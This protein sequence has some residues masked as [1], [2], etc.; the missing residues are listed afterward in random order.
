MF[1]PFAF[2]KQTSVSLNPVATTW[3]STAGISNTSVISAVSTF[4]DT[5]QSQAIWSKMVAVYPL[6][7]DS[8]TSST[9]K[10]QFTYN[11]VN[12]STYAATYLNNSSTGGYGGLTNAG[13]DTFITTTPATIGNN[14]VFGFY[15]NSDAASTDVID[16]GVY[17]PSG[18]DQGYAY[19]IAGRNKVGSNA[20]ILMAASDAIFP[21]N[22]TGTGPFTGL[23][24]VGGNSTTGYAYR[25]TSQLGTAASYNNA[26][27][28]NSWKIGLGSFLQ[29]NTTAINPTTKTYQFCFMSTFLDTTEFGNLATAVND[30]QGS[31]DTIFSTT[32]KAY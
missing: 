14:Y 23:F 6:I 30:L 26:K 11:L 28:G 7:S 18:A 19:I 17:D 25:R 31:I 12:P 27:R 29:E 9:A 2:V 8:N 4:V 21:Y 15:T 22:V 1:T 24:G 20:Q 32:R 16:M 3:A 10:T 5:L 13:G